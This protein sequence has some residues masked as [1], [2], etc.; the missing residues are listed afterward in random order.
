MDRFVSET[1]NFSS[2]HLLLNNSLDIFGNFF[3]FLNSGTNLTELKPTK[4][5]QTTHK[6]MVSLSPACTD[7]SIQQPGRSINVPT[8]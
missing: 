1:I 7:F 5:G 6:K 8:E 3:I 2:R 4:A